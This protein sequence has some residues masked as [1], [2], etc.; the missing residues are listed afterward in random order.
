[1]LQI[2]S[3]VVV[4]MFLLVE[5]ISLRYNLLSLFHTFAKENL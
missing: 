5:V 3:H 1:V 4:A 2:S